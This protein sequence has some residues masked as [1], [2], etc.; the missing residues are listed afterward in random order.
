[1]AALEALV[2]ESAHHH[3]TM[4]E[5]A[6]V[7][8]DPDHRGLYPS[9]LRRDPR[10]LGRV[11]LAVHALWH[12]V[13]FYDDAMAAG[14]VTAEWRDRRDYLDR[15]CIDGLATLQRALPHLTRAGRSLIELAGARIA[16]S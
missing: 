3:F 6:A 11:L 16:K 1:V 7:F 12:M 4:S 5:V 10:P 14:L 15:Q 13:I 9:P 2:H 8:V